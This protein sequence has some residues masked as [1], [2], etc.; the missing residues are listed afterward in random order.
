MT[1]GKTAPKSATKAALTRLTWDQVL[2]HRMRVHHLDTPAPVGDLL[3]VV[4][5]ICCLHAQLLSS[6]ELSL[7]ARV[8]GVTAGEA[9]R[10]LWD[11]RDLVKIWAMRGTLH[12]VAARHYPVWQAALGTYRHYTKPSWSKYFKITQEQLAVMLPAIDEALSGRMLGR[13][14]L[15]DEVAHRT[16][17]PE[18]ADRL[19][20]NWG[21]TLKPSSFLGQLCFA[22]NRGPNVQFTSPR[23][24]LAAPPAAVDAGA[25]LATVTRRYLSAYGPA[26][27]EDYARWWGHSPATAG[28]LITGLGDEVVA[29]DVEGVCGWMLASDAEAAA[30]SAGPGVARLLP[31]FDPWVIGASRNVSAYIADQFR[32][33]VYRPQGWISPVVLVDGR[34]VGTWRHDVARGQV[35][36]TVAPFPAV[37]PLSD[38]RGWAYAAVEAEAAR[39]A[40]FLGGS[41]SYHLGAA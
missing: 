37:G 41:L 13:D 18:L 6:A 29:V 33:L 27:R 25:A 4:D 28:R 23:S 34:I 10:A 24:W 31:A 39:L 2:A 32:D 17:I 14:E 21:A 12:L 1:V 8:A 30:T 40:D 19:R 36:V 20:D 22:P 38:A 9:E 7:W 5:R 3:E 15:A 35:T 16:G 11:R 26:S